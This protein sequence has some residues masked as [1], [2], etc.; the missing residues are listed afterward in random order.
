L[1]SN[2]WKD[3]I[4]FVIARNRNEDQVGGRVAPGE[5]QNVAA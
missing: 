4:E 3:L 1:L 5:G 2:Q